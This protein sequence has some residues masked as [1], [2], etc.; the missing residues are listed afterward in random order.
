MYLS[1]GSYKMKLKRELCALRRK[2]L[3]AL[4]P[5]RATKGAEKPASWLD[6]SFGCW[7]PIWYC[8]FI[9]STS[10][11]SLLPFLLPL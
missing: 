5:R 4:A 10:V 7:L 6:D 3:D 11:A 8:P 2:F 9:T 1:F